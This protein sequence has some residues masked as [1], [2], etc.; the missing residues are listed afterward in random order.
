MM[1]EMA[2]FQIRDLIWLTVV[3]SLVTMLFINKLNH[4]RTLE[5]LQEQ[6][7]IQLDAFPSSYEDFDIYVS[8]KN[9]GRISFSGPHQID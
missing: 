9:A 5:T 1:K 4:T 6:Q 7:A 2:K 3:A 8:A